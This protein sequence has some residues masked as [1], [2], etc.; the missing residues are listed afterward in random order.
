MIGRGITKAN[1]EAKIEWG[2]KRNIPKE[3]L[4][5]WHDTFDPFTKEK[6]RLFR[7]KCEYCGHSIAFITNKKRICSFCKNYVDP[8]GHYEFR[9]KLME[10]MKDNE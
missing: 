7:K 8:T 9:K 2:V 3:E 4:N 1:T 10:V 6:V 5:N